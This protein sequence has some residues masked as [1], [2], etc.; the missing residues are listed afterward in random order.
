[1]R[2]RSRTMNEH[3][4]NPPRFTTSRRSFLMASSIGAVAGSLG[5][6]RT[7]HAAGS[8]AIKIA[9]I[10]CGGRGTGAAINA[11]NACPN[12]RLVALADA[13]QARVDISL[14]SILAQP[15]ADRVDIPGNW[16]FVGLDS[17]Q[18]AIESDVD[19]VL[20][21]SPPGFRPIQYEAAVAAGKHVFMEKPL[22]TDAPGLRR[23]LAANNLAKEKGL[24]VAVGHHLR[25][26]DRYRE[27]VQRIHDGAIGK[28]MLMRAYFNTHNLW[29]RP[30][31][32]GQSEMEYQVQ[33]WYYFTWLS[34]DH[35]VEQHV[36][37][38]DI[39]NWI[40]GGHPVSAQG[41]GGRQVRIGKEYGDIFDHHAVEFT[42]PDG[43]KMYSY[44]RQTPGCWTS[45]SQHAHGTKGSARLDGEGT[46]E[47]SIDGE[48]SKRWDRG[49][50][51]H[52]VEMDDLFAAYI[53]GRPT[54]EVDAT[55][56]GT[57]TAILGRMATYSGKEV[58]WDDAFHSNLDLAPE[59]LTWDAKPRV[60]PDEKG[61][62]PCAVPGVTQAW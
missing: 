62:Y 22:A 21:C 23:I 28:L 50:D 47:L 48:P 3:T 59:T 58:S 57:M 36:H 51:G 45:F 15:C 19:M 18:P 9:L 26:E 7:A 52:Q 44:C 41:M 1:M 49:K 35:I 25:H 29:V 46:A 60:L 4:S 6:A 37:D 27:L 5:I 24:L 38:I 31:K 32:P 17:Y 2:D 20:L 54:N 61:Y 42:Y 13:F 16:Q 34:G 8:D 14:K 12:T 56:D 11:L 55:A 40:H 10:G 43:V 39:C 33:N 30:R 53:G